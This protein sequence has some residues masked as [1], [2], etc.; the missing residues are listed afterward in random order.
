M[1][2]V[3]VSGTGCRGRL[4]PGSPLVFRGARPPGRSCHRR[5]QAKLAVEGG[6]KWRAPRGC[7]GSCISGWRRIGD[8][9]SHRALPFRGQH[10]GRRSR[11]HRLW[12]A[13]PQERLHRDRD[14]ANGGT[15]VR[16]ERRADHRA[17]D[18]ALAA[19]PPPRSRAQ[20]GPRDSLRGAGSPGAGAGAICGCQDD[21]RK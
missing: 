19:A 5:D 4:D 11:R 8:I 21:R 16:G 1:G 7:S 20:S 10:H 9:G 2:A 18:R 3:P 6:D 12:S 15:R 13:D 17:R 14:S